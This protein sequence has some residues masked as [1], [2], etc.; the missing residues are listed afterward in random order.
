TKGS[1]MILMVWPVLPTPNVEEADRLWNATCSVQG[2]QQPAGG[3]KRA[4]GR[5]IY[6]RGGPKMVNRL[7]KV[8]EVLSSLHREESGQDLIEYALLAA[9]I[10]LAATFGMGVVASDINNAFSKIGSKLSA[11]VT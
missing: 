1:S 6:S 7:L 10:A 2:R 5:K 4:L 3:N 9:L 8:R 11:T